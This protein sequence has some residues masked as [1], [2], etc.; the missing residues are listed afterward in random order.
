MPRRDRWLAVRTGSRGSEPGKEGL[1]EPPYPPWNILKRG[2][3]EAWKLLSRCDLAPEGCPVRLQSQAHPILQPSS[4][5]ALGESLSSTRSQLPR[6][7]N[8]GGD[9]NSRHSLSGSPGA[10]FIRWLT[11]SSQPPHGT[12]ATGT[13]VQKDSTQ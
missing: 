10:E 3:L 9:S 1:R 13:E 6:L 5:V 4:C 8:G 2:P 12:G 11:E 7:F